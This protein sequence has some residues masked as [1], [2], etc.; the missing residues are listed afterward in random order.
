MRSMGGVAM[1]LKTL[2]DFV[3]MDCCKKVDTLN[4]CA[5]LN[6]KTTEHF[7]STKELKAAAIKWVKA[8]IS[9]Q[10]E[11]ESIKNSEFFCGT[12]CSWDE[13]LSDTEGAIGILKHFFN[14]T[15]GDLN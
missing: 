12:W 3:C 2:K 9:K 6:T 13:E 5:H 8:I 11:M 7:V 4:N 14:I 1:T 15:E 10:E